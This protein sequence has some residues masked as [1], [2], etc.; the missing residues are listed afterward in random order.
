MSH[1]LPKPLE[2]IRQLIEIPSVS[3]T[4]AGLDQSN[5]GVIERLHLWLSELGFNCEVMPIPDNPGKAN[6]IATLGSGPGGLVLSGHTDTVPCDID[7]WQSNPF[8]VTERDQRLY[9]LGTCDMKGFLALAITAAS[10]FANT[11]LKHPLIL[12]ATADEESAMCGARALV[13]AGKPQARA[14]VIGEPTSLKP[15]RMHK[16]IMM[17]AVRIKGSSGHSSNPAL[18]ANA[19]EAMHQ[20]MSHLL[21]YRQELQ[22]RYSNA[23]FTVAAPTLNLG[24]I[25]GGDN[26]NRICGRCEMEYD[27]RPLPGMM[28]IEQLRADIATRLTPVAEQFGVQLELENLFPGIPPTIPIW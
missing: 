16:G 10:E 28:S 12:L 5:L 7:L 13:N 9:G 27:L 15:I 11:P 23:A 6:L 26:P 1:A 22:S 14:A 8:K 25:H 4:S 20:V 18:G 3:A 19:L 24:C 21:N 17:E 2:L